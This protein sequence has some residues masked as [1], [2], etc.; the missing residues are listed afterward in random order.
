M[1]IESILHRKGSDVVM[2][3]PEA[4][5]LHAV[6]VLCERG[7]G[8]LVVSADGR[9][10]DGIISERDVNQALARYGTETLD[11]RVD[12]IMTRQ[13]HTCTRD[14]TVDQL[15]ATMTERRVRHVPVVADGDVV[16][17]VSIGDVVKT[18][19]DELEAEARTLHEYIVLGR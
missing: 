7:I 5:V 2:V 6:N 18:R 9:H 15:M 19:L 16:G 17:I 1:R 13:V 8:A 12:E 11:R 4:T 14:D 10:I 3:T